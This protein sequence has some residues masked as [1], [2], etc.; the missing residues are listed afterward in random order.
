MGKIIKND[1]GYEYISNNGVSYEIGECGAEFN[2]IVDSALD[3]EE[4]Y[5][6]LIEFK[7]HLVDYVY[8]GIEDEETL[9]WIDWRIEQYENHERILRFDDHECYVGLKEEQHK[10][11]TRITEKEMKGWI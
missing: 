3:Y 7:C 5:D 1:W 10:T 9:E 4:K 8:G 2:I 11:Y 6:G